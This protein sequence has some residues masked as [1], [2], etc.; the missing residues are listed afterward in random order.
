MVED[1][2]VT[3]RGPKRKGG[4][5]T[6]AE[7]TAK[8]L[9]A[10]G[11]D[12]TTIDPMSILAAIAADPSAPASAR[13]QACKALIAARDP[14]RAEDPGGDTRINARAAAMMRHAN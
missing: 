5:P 3:H 11:V 8:A 14:E 1:P 7:A 9:A 13:V 6:R 4:R 10:I 2:A 12:P